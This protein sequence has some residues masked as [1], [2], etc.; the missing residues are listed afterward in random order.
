M[1][2]FQQIRKDLINMLEELDSHLNLIDPDTD[3][4]LST[5]GKDDIEVNPTKDITRAISRIDKGTYGM[6]LNCGRLIK[7]E[8]LKVNPLSKLCHC[9][10]NEK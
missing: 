4:P 7:K 5:E 10:S 6:C 1:G 2:N 9:C 3:T 8:A